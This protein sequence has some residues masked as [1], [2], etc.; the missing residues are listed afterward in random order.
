MLIN[1]ITDFSKNEYED[2]S[3]KYSCDDCNH[4]YECPKDNSDVCEDC[5]DCLEQIHYH[6]S[7]GKTD[8]DCINMIN[9]YVCCYIFKYASEILYLI[10]Q[11]DL[12]KELNEYNILS[13][14]CGACPDLMA[15]EKYNEYDEKFIRYTGIDINKLWDDVHTE[16]FDYTYNKNIETHF[17][18]EDAFGVVESGDIANINIIILQ[19][20]IS[21]L[22]NTDQIDDFFDNLVENIISNNTN[23]EPIIIMINDANSYKCGRDCFIKLYNKLIASGYD[24]TYKKFYFH[25][26]SINDYQRYGTMHSNNRI[27]FNVSGDFAKYHVWKRCTSSQLIIEIKRG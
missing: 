12:I 15:F 11:S 10:R 22:N 3:S 17:I 6:D 5:K 24:C 1:R 20:F 14:G 7:K 18:C 9:F 21:H 26:S 19:Y 4:C 25:Y 2:N 23:S 13:F 27:L 8:Y 16:I